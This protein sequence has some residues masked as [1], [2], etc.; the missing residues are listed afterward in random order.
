MQFINLWINKVLIL[1]LTMTLVG[2]ILTIRFLIQLILLLILLVYF[3]FLV[4]NWLCLSECPISFIFLF[5]VAFII[6]FLLL[7]SFSTALFAL[8]FIYLV[9][10][11]LLHTHISIAS[12]PYLPIVHVSQ[13]YNSILQICFVC[14]I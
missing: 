10:I 1:K 12:N 13:L 8:C 6:V 2:L 5:I 4:M 3:F 14:T 9:P 7:T 11:I